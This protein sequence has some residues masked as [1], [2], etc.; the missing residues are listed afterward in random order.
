MKKV[1]L[2]FFIMMFVSFVQADSLKS[3]AVKAQHLFSWGNKV[4]SN[5]RNNYVRPTHENE[6]SRAEVKLTIKGNGYIEKWWF[7]HKGSVYFNHAITGAIIKSLPLPLP[8][9]V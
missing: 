8:R 7:T 3:S 9:L 2:I 4:Y 6:Y 1:S 5:I